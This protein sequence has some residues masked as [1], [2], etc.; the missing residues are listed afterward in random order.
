[1]ELRVRGSPTPLHP[2]PSY[3]DGR[4]LIFFVLAIKN[5]YGHPARVLQMNIA[6]LIPSTLLACGL[7]IGSHASADVIEGVLEKGLVYSALFTASQG[8]GDLIGQAFRNQS[9]VGKEILDHCLPEMFCKIAQGTTKDL[10][11]T[12][13]L[14]FED[15][16]QG[17]VE[18]TSAKGVAMETVVFGHEKTESTRFGKVSIRESD[19]RVMFRG[20]A[21]A[22]ALADANPLT[23]AAKYEVGARDV[24]LLQ[25]TGGV[26][27]PALFWFVTVT[28]QGVNT[29]DSFGSCS[30]VIYPRF[31]GAQVTVS[32][33][34]F[35]GPLQSSREKEQAKRTRL[36][37]VFADGKVTLNG[38][39]LR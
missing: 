36:D 3:P 6:K 16:P 8:S 15:D 30:D 25:E 29:T 2:D 19:N 37:F 38:K 26:A 14:K 20:A 17:W 21:V 4:D 27:C 24:L 34:G 11:D 39:P 10:T 31:K 32:M 13:H 35:A 22:P 12:R 9:A 7:L 18:I 5:S 23:I 1:M 33:P 28:A